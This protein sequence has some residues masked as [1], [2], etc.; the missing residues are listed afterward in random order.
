MSGKIPSSPAMVDKIADERDSFCRALRILHCS[1]GHL[2]RTWLHIRERQ[3]VD[4]NRQVQAA[5]GQGEGGRLPCGSC[6]FQPS[7]PTVFMRNAPCHR[8]QTAECHCPIAGKR[9]RCSCGQAQIFHIADDFA[10]MMLAP[11]ADADFP[12]EL[13]ASSWLQTL[14]HLQPCQIRAVS[15]KHSEHKILLT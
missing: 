9:E 7:G 13:T 3:Q 8:G 4:H 1:G 6:V 15:T 11:F 2:R 5:Q 12:P 14:P 10:D